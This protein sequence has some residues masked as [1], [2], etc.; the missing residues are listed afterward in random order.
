MQNY[1][2]MI[3]AA[4]LLTFDAVVAQD[5]VQ[6]ARRYLDA[7]ALTTLVVG[8]RSAIA[9]SIEALGLGP[10]DVLPVEV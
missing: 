5:V 4:V 2:A 1:V 8:D 6:A 3:L 10:P 9:D 7:S